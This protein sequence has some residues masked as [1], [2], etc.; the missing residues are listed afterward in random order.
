VYNKNMTVSFSSS[1]LVNRSF[2]IVDALQTL[3]PGAQWVLEGDSYEGLAWLDESQEQP[4]EQ[5]LLNEASRLQEEYDALE[6]QRLRQP[7]YPPIE[8]YVDGIVKGDQEQ[9][10]SYI[11]A[12]LAVKEKY[13]K[14]E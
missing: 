11:A 1:S 3:T 13:P 4:N 12:C 9:I 7:E 5:D 8:D 10:D 14:P 2:G 6:Y